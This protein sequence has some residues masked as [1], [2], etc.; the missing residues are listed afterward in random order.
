[1]IPDLYYPG[2]LIARDI[3]LIADIVRPH[4]HLLVEP[5][6][7]ERVVPHIP[8]DIPVVPAIPP[9]ALGAVP[10]ALASHPV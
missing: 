6:I 8:P 4:R 5:D 9:E 3:G 1:M 10:L 7:V 2:S